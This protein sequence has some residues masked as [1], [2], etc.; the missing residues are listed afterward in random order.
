VYNRSNYSRSESIFD[1][2]PKTEDGSLTHNES[3]FKGLPGSESSSSNAAYYDYRDRSRPTSITVVGVLLVISLGFGLVQVL[4]I[5]PD[6]KYLPGWVWL[7]LLAD[8][9]LLIAGIVG[10]FQM[11]KYGAWAF[12]AQSIISTVFSLALGATS[13]GLLNLVGSVIIL[14]FVFRK[15]DEME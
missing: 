1:R 4:G 6:A 14:I 3:L 7:V 11:K 10:L 8:Y 5:L 9:G 13:T 12:L 15:Y 2:L